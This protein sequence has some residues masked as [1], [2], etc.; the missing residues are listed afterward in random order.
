MTVSKPLKASADI[1]ELIDFTQDRFEQH[2]NTA[3][4]QELSK[5]GGLQMDRLRAEDLK[6][7]KVVTTPV[8]TI[9]AIKCFVDPD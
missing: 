9:R 3:L 5:L 2:G 6:E 4:S 7:E 1:V 8:T